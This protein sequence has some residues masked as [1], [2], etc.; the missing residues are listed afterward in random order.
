M[1]LLFILVV[2]VLPISLF[3]CYFFMQCVLLYCGEWRHLF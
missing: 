2:F 1:S 3:S